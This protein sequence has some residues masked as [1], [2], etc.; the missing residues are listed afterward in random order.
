MS[1]VKRIVII[2]LA[3]CAAPAAAHHSYAMFDA[4]KEIVLTGVV[5]DWKWTNPHTFMTLTMEDKSGRTV[6]W[7][8]DGQSP[9]VLRRRGFAREMSKV[10]DR[11]S[12]R[13][14]PLRDGSN[15]GQFVGM[16]AA[17]GKIYR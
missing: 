6:D 15:G 8:L 13:M 4:T 7:S 5:K 2:A 16:T 17:D 12:V 9:Q 14:N 3:A 1:S 11:I 10:G